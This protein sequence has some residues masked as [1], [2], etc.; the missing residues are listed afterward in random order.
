MGLSIELSMTSAACA[1]RMPVIDP[2]SK[3]RVGKEL[4]TIGTHQPL[5]SYSLAPFASDAKRRVSTTV[6]CV[7]I[8]PTPNELGHRVYILIHHRSAHT[9][10]P[11]SAGVGSPFKGLEEELVEK[12]HKARVDR[13]ARHTV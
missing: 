1:V 9:P 2:P 12:K 3:T 4:V 6:D 7:Y 11:P 8:H 10:D 13:F 5:D